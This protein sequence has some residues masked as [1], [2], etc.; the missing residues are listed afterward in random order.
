VRDPNDEKVLAAA[1]GNRAGYLVTGDED[2][3]ALRDD[4]RIKGLRIV[5][6]REFLETLQVG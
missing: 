4:P 6:A 5:T 2:L 3:L 1:L